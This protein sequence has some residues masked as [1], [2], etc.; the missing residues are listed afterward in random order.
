MPNTVVHNNLFP[1]RS[2]SY[3]YILPHRSYT[4]YINNACCLNVVCECLITN[5]SDFLDHRHIS[6]YG[7][8]FLYVRT[9]IHLKAYYKPNHSF[10]RLSLCVCVCVCARARARNGR[11]RVVCYFS[12]SHSPHASAFRF[13]DIWFTKSYCS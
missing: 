6:K 3:L 7:F 12:M 13:T 4:S 8:L 9:Q 1:S 5:T 11:Y 10:V 2:L